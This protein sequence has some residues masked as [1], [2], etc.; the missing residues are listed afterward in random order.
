MNDPAWQALTPDLVP[1]SKLASAVAL[2][3]AGFNI[4]RAVGPALGGLVIATAGL[5]VGCFSAECALILRRDPVSLSL[6]AGA[7]ESRTTEP[8][9]S[10]GAMSI[11]L[12]YARQEPRIRAVLV[13][14]LAIFI[15]ASAFWA[16]LPLIASKFGA[17]GFGAMLAFFGLGALVGAAFLRWR[18]AIFPPMR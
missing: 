1:A 14:T 17:E 6:E 8:P 9:P 7:G 4:A 3:S 10:S 5:T 18:V 16:L 15:F 13:R 11:G 2:N 12:R